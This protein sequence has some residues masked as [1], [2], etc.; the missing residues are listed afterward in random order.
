MAEG[1]HSSPGLPTL[2]GRLTRTGLGA[3]RNRFE[4]LTV[5]WQQERIRLRQMLVWAVGLLFLGM[6]GIFLL[7]A[8]IIF[9][10]PEEQ[11]LYAAA[12]FAVLY[13]IGAAVAWFGLRSVLKREPF[14]ATIDQARK[15]QAWLENME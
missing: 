2:L 4:L 15:D 12:G 14:E 11:R 10:F 7:T 5:E 6:M 13:L 8:T 1:N 3:L 9:L